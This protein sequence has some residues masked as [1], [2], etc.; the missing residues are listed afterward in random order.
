MV[1]RAGMTDT[2]IDDILFVVYTERFSDGENAGD[3]DIT[4]LISARQAT[5]F[6]R[7]IYYGKFN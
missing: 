7:G 2:V 6:E 1:G 4:R 3:T 5:S